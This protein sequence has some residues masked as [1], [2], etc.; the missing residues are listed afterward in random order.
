MKSMR[1]VAQKPNC[2]NTTHRRERAESTVESDS[3]N[4]AD[5]KKMLIPW[6]HSTTVPWRVLR[7][8]MGCV[9]LAVL[10][11][12]QDARDTSKAAEPAEASVTQGTEEPLLAANIRGKMG[13]INPRG[14]VRIPAQFEAATDFREGLAAVGLGG[15]RDEFGNAKG[16]V[17]GYIDARGKIVINPQF[18]RADDYAEGLAAV[19]YQTPTERGQGVAYGYIDKS[20]GVVIP[21]RFASAGR[22]SQGL[23]SVRDEEGRPWGFIDRE[24]RVVIAPEYEWANEFKDGHAVVKKD[25]AWGLID[26]TGRWV[27]PP[28]FSYLVLGGSDGLFSAAIEGVR[29]E[30]CQALGRQKICWGPLPFE[31]PAGA[32]WGFVDGAGEWKIL[33]IFSFAGAFSEGLARVA[34]GEDPF[35]RGRWGYVD[36]SGA[37]VINP[38]FEVAMP[39]SDGLAAVRVGGRWGYIDRSGQFVIPPSFEGVDGELLKLPGSF[40]HGVAS[41]PRAHEGKPDVFIDRTGGIVFDG[42]LDVSRAENKSESQGSV[43]RRGTAFFVTAAGHLVT[44]NHVVQGCRVVKL[45]SVPDTA[46]IV[47]VDRVNDLA[48]LKSSRPV[49]GVATF[50]K[51]GGVRQGEE[52]ASYGYPLKGIL[53]QGGNFTSGAVSAITGLNDNTSQF[54]VTAPIQPGSSGAPVLDR[55]GEVLG[56]IVG[57]L[58]AAKLARATGDIPQNV[59]FAISGSVVQRFLD[60]HGV[61][62]E[63]SSWWSWSKK[64]ERLAESAKEYTVPLECAD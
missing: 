49:V 17:W 39:F 62:Y 45:P 56:V 36:T 11:G 8:L 6:E 51:D 31:P 55:R 58:D 16:Q 35:A 9:S 40:K 54:Q 1:L 47:A 61:V 7:L 57:K 37:F 32:K 64:T 15:T 21:A 52:V 29:K 2:A 53:S 5:A 20:G 24:G 25:G 26:K 48:L 60:A 19:A 27:V 18:V 13:Y 28:K 3:T 30:T 63:T 10:V 34:V 33:P 38:Q 23:A 22:F 44:N 42:R 50:R 12:C 43:G 41:L 46:T 59:N 4:R 14:E